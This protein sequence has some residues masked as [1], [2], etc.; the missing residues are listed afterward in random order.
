MNTR[1]L[2]DDLCRDRKMFCCW[3]V[4]EEFK[5]RIG[6]MAAQVLDDTFFREGPYLN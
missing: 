1:T 5:T 6:V 4:P 2:R 3:N